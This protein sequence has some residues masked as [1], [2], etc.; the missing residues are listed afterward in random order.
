LERNMT[1]VF[2]QVD[3]NMMRGSGEAP[4]IK[5]V[6]VGFAGGV[7]CDHL[8]RQRVQAERFIAINTHWRDLL[9]CR[10]PCK[11]EIGPELTSGL[12]SGC[13]PARGFEAAMESR[14]EIGEN[15][16]GAEVVIVLAGLGGGTGTGSAPVVAGLARKQHA[17]TIGVVSK[18]FE[19]EG[20]RRQEHSDEGLRCLYERVDCLIVI[21]NEGFLETDDANLNLL[22]A[23]K[24]S[25]DAFYRAI[26]AISSLITT[27]GGFN[28]DEAPLEPEP[29]TRGHLCALGHGQMRGAFR[30]REATIRALSSRL[31]N[32][33]RA[34]QAR[35]ILVNISTGHDGT[36]VEVRES[37]ELIQGAAGPE[38]PLVFNHVIDPHFSGEF[39][40]T[41]MLTGLELR[42]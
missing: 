42:Y 24:R 27:G 41:L 8:M 9:S 7:I 14:V 22:D 21:E 32:G 29:S 37:V 17:F 36:L 1:A 26:H 20:A 12:G 15:L 2:T 13:R 11:L 39:N 23:Y 35:G 19:F 38:V 18:P 6:G 16:A 5:V 10:V 31:L 30:A 40:V 28:C 4:A 25:N 34:H 3:W 33:V